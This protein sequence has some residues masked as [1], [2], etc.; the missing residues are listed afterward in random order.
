MYFNLS[1]VYPKFL[2]LDL[3]LSYIFILIPLYRLFSTKLHICD[4]NTQYLRWLFF[5]NSLFHS[6]VFHCFSSI[7]FLSYFLPLFYLLT[8]KC[9]FL[10]FLFSLLFI[11]SFHVFYGDF[12]LFFIRCITLYPNLFGLFIWLI[13]S[14]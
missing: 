4:Y 7:F 1:L 12:S 11:F 3:F 14:L 13:L 5:F 10:C 8:F 2:I 9:F 6:I